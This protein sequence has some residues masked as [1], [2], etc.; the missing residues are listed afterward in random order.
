MR[1]ERPFFLRESHT[2]IIFPTRHPPAV[3]NVPIA[4]RNNKSFESERKFIV[5]S[6]FHIGILYAKGIY[7]WPPSENVTPKCHAHNRFQ[8]THNVFDM[9]NGIILDP[10]SMHFSSILFREWKALY[11]WV[12]KYYA[13]LRNLNDIKHKIYTHIFLLD[14]WT[15]SCFKLTL[16]LTNRS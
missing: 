15:G 6:T 13:V 14:K 8:P 12:P 1:R 5:R 16:F 9:T 3:I 10:V 11:P 4:A 7:A 2:V